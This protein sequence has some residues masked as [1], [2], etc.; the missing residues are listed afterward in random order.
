[1]PLCDK[2]VV[3]QHEVADKGGEYVTKGM[4][5]SMILYSNAKKY[6]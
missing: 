6:A 3:S 5:H 1:M 4:L 2:N